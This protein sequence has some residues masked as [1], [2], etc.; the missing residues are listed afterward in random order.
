MSPSLEELKATLSGLSVP[1]RAE[2]AQYLL[3]SL[4]QDA[5]EAWRTELA[6]RLTDIRSGKVVGK[7]VEQVLARLREL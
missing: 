7:P 1:Q 4:D 6:R 3:Q 5:A 2:L